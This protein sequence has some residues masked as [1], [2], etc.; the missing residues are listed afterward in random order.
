MKKIFLLYFLCST[1]FYSWSQDFVYK[2]GVTKSLVAFNYHINDTSNNHI[3]NSNLGIDY[4][5]LW[6]ENEKPIFVRAISYSQDKKLIYNKLFD[7]KFKGDSLDLLRQFGKLNI[8]HPKFSLKNLY[9]KETINFP[10]HWDIQSTIYKDS[11]IQKVNYR[12]GK[13]SHGGAYIGWAPR[14]N[15]DYKVLEEEIAKELKLQ[16]NPKLA[17]EEIVLEAKIEVKSDGKLKD[18]KLIYGENSILS[19]IAISNLLKDANT[20]E[21]GVSESGR[22][23]SSKIKFYIS[24]NHSGKITIIPSKYLYYYR[25]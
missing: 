12:S 15:R 14:F 11:V 21:P 19:D 7:L 6:F 8:F 18:L 13:T 5:N 22:N 16:K 23:T 3:F 17:F 25:D 10:T 24:Q 9:F 4:F 1:F 20:W 2:E